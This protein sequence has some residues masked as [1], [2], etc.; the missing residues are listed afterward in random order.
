MDR[1]NLLIYLFEGF[2]G[3]HDAAADRQH[4]FDKA[5]P[6]AAIRRPPTKLAAIPR[7]DARFV[8]R[9]V[10]V[11]SA[12]KALRYSTR[13]FGH[14]FREVRIEVSAFDPPGQPVM[15]QIDD[16]VDAER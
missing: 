6:T 15:D 10:K 11:N 3:E 7:C 13:V 12:V 8:Q 5:A 16:G 1:Q 4:D 14:Q 9:R 2:D